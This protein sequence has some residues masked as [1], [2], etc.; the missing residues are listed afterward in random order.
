MGLLMAVRLY[1]KI[2][3]SL[4]LEISEGTI[5]HRLISSSG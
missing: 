1:Q 4:R 2:K 3:D 5:L